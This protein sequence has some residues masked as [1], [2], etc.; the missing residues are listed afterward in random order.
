MQRVVRFARVARRL[1]A[2]SASRANVRFLGGGQ[3]LAAA[4]LRSDLDGQGGPR[5][6]CSA[7]FCSARSATPW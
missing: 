6:G 2:T 5:A 1:T 3:A 4:A 7:A